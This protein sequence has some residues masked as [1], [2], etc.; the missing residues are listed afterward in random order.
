M[1][2]TKPERTAGNCEFCGQKISSQMKR[3]RTRR[4][5][6]EQCWTEGYL[7]RSTTSYDRI[8]AAFDVARVGM[9]D[10]LVPYLDEA[11]RLVRSTIRRRFR[12]SQPL[13]SGQ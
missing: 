6:S 12:R 1:A 4:Y 10:D 5:C 3:G 9:P 7:Q 2:R 13:L 11:R 8:M